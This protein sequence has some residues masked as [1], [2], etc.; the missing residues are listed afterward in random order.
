VIVLLC[1]WFV[2][3]A[4]ALRAVLGVGCSDE[5]VRGVSW[6]RATLVRMGELQGP[7]VR[8]A[9]ELAAERE[10]MLSE[11]VERLSAMDAVRAAAEQRD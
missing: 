11:L 9:D 4:C 2:T 1:C 6:G 3:R 10:Q 8:S 5:R 7:V